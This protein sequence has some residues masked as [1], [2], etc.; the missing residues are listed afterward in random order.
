MLADNIMLS[1][2]MLSENILLS[3]NMIFLF[4]NFTHSIT[5]LS[6]NIGYIK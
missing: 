1:D 4:L 6:Y 5:E 3:D 2:N